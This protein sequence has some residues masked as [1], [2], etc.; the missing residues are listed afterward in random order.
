MG[1]GSLYA[2]FVPPPLDFL[3]QSPTAAQRSLAAH[4]SRHL[5]AFG[6]SVGFLMLAAIPISSCLSELSAFFPQRLVWRVT[7]ML[8]PP[9]TFMHRGDP[10]SDFKPMWTE[11]SP[12]ETAALARLCD[13]LGLLHLE[14]A[15]MPATD[16]YLLARAF[17][18]CKGPD[19]DRQVIGGA[20]SGPKRA[21]ADLVCS[22]LLALC[23]ACSR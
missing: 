22:S 20:G 10:P 19:K 1:L 7:P 6:A 9:L 2:N 15:D 17:N 8:T 12:I 16:S 18:C 4:V 3:A 5:K 13:K 23:W 14:P 11:E 21:S